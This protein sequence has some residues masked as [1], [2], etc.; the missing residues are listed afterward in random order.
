MNE[1]VE[2]SRQQVLTEA[3]QVAEFSLHLV[4]PFTFT[5][6]IHDFVDSYLQ[7][8]TVANLLSQELPV[9]LEAFDLQDL[10][11]TI[12]PT[13][14]SETDSIEQEQEQEDNS[15]DENTDNNNPEVKKRQRQIKRQ[16]KIAKLKTQPLWQ[17]CQPAISEDLYPHIRQLLSAQSHELSYCYELNDEAWQ[18]L[19]GGLGRFDKGMAIDLSRSAV[20]RLGMSQEQ[21]PYIPFSFCRATNGSHNQK[22]RLYLFSFGEGLLTVELSID[23]HFLKQYQTPAILEFVHVMAHADA[24][25]D[26]VSFLIKKNRDPIQQTQNKCQIID[27]FYH[28]LGQS[29]ANNSQQEV[30]S[31]ECSTTT[32]SNNP[33]VI[34]REKPRRFFTYSALRFDNMGISLQNGDIEI[35]KKK[36]S[37]VA[38]SLAHRHTFHYLPTKQNIEEKVYLPF[39]NIAHCNSI[40]GGA[41]VINTMYMVD[42]NQQKMA[43][44]HNKQFIKDTIRHA[45]LPMVLLS[46]LEFNYLIKLT[47]D[48]CPNVSL[49]SANEDTVINLEKLR[50]EMLSFRLHFRYSQ[51]SQLAQHNDFYNRWR[52]SFGNDSLANELADDILQINNLL[53]YRLEQNKQ[54]LQ[55]QQNKWFTA[56][57]ILATSLL[58]AIGVFGTNFYTY[59]NPDLRILS[60]V[61]FITFGV[62]LLVGAAAILVYLKIINKNIYSIGK[63]STYNNDN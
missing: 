17:V 56:L 60:P 35:I 16:Q 57:G 29:I 58:S 28:L 26:N 52:H 48:I 40:E 10:E 15:N 33:S 22:P 25:S 32:Q 53:T 6:N 59:N 12:L 4:Y 8:Q 39:V 24:H 1:T 50:R 62:S 9:F 5:G 19:D 18:L 51:A 37:M 44:E 11:N 46:Y 36:I 30:A 63:K 54:A 42:N 14:I 47:S 23:K 31:T 34:A 21:T 7:Q 61:T 27:I 55:E 20:S 45:Y 2:Q 13:I 43:I 38:F 49:I 3:T 41:V